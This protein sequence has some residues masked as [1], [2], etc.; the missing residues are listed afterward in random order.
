MDNLP[1][2]IKLQILGYSSIWDIIHFSLTSKT[3]SKLICDDFHKLT[4]LWY[5]RLESLVY[6]EVAYQK[7]DKEEFVEFLCEFDRIDTIGLFL[8]YLYKP[9]NTTQLAQYCFKGNSVNTFLFLKNKIRFEWDNVCSYVTSAIGN[10][11][12]TEEIF[13]IPEL[14]S[15]KNQ[16]NWLYSIVCHDDAEY[17][18]YVLK[19]EKISM[20][21][22][23]LWNWSINQKSPKCLLWL[24]RSRGCW[25]DDNTYRWDIVH[26]FHDDL[27]KLETILQAGQFDDDDLVETVCELDE[28]SDRPVLQTYNKYVDWSEE[29]LKL[30]MRSV[31]SLNMEMF[32]DLLVKKIMK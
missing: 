3:N 13:K 28:Y 1:P 29:N 10:Y 32:Y 2:E 16:F 8:S 4:N 24:Y 17:L 27:K 11:E 5:Y 19:N 15:E 12:I 21:R 23:T 18:D 26:I 25:Y 14:L 7:I 20:S 22:I 31:D 30:L 9:V 6:S